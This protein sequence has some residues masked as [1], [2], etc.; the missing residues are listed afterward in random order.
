MLYS[1]TS[2]VLVA[3]GST[4][5]SG[6]M[7]NNANGFFGHNIA[8]ALSQGFSY[9]EAILSHVNVPLVSP[10]NLSREFQLSPNIVLGD[11]TLKAR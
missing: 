5:N 7:G 1:P 10:Y 11:P 6:G 4:N 3:R 8:T 2:S 9:G